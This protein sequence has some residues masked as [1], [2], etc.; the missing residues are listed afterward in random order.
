MRDSTPSFRIMSSLNGVAF[1]CFLAATVLAILNLV[2]LMAIPLAIIWSLIGVGFLLF[3]VT[4]ILL[5]S[6]SR[7]M[8]KR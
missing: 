2:G 4:V 8:T 1:A 6:V 5:V 3:L 7:S